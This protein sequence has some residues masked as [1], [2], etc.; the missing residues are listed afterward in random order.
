MA[1]V[2]GLTLKAWKI[3]GY[4]IVPAALDPGIQ[5][6]SFI[7]SQVCVLCSILRERGA[8]HLLLTILYLLSHLLALITLLLGKVLV[9]WDGWHLSSYKLEMTALS[10]Y[11]FSKVWTLLLQV[12]SS[13]WVKQ[14]LHSCC[15]VWSPYGCSI[16]IFCGMY[17]MCGPKLASPS[18]QNTVVTLLCH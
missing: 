16:N 15:L 9:S 14:M 6:L 12:Y 3:A 5:P 1:V 17:P 8:D 4:T 18:P 13:P 7:L 11:L 2:V 10:P